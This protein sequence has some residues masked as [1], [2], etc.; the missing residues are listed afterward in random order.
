MFIG[1]IWV[2]THDEKRRE[3]SQ[4]MIA[5]AV[6][7]LVLSTTV[8]FFVSVQQPDSLP[9]SSLLLKHVIVDIVRLDEGLVKYRNTFPGGP[10][11]FFADISQ[12]S[13][14]TKNV[15]YLLQTLVGDAVVVRR[16]SFS[17]CPF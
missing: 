17:I 9:D 1:T 12:W 13:Y 10:V 6:I 15:I 14:V 8:S 16:D 11:A 4:M 7:F 2:L 3:S 5:V